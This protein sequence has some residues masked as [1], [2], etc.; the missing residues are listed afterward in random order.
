MQPF[1]THYGRADLTDESIDYFVGNVL[2]QALNTLTEQIRRGLFF[3]STNNLEEEATFDALVEKLTAQFAAEL[4]AIRALIV[5]DICAAMSGDL[6]AMSISEILICYPGIS[7][8]IHYRI[9][10]TLYELGAT[11]IGKIHF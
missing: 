4:P 11:V 6:A 2:S 10:H 3:S 5:S 7:A 8:V 9:A 1:S